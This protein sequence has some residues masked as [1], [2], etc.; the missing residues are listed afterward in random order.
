MQEIEINHPVVDF[1]KY[2]RDLF[3]NKEEYNHSLRLN[4]VSLN[5]IIYEL[6]EEG[7]YLKKIENFISYLI[8]NNC[9]VLIMNECGNKKIEL[10]NY[11][12]FFYKNKEQNIYEEYYLYFPFKGNENLIKEIK[13][14]TCKEL[15]L[16]EDELTLTLMT[17]QGEL[18]IDSFSFN[19]FFIT[20]QNIIQNV[21]TYISEFNEE[22]KTLKKD[23]FDD[24][25]VK[26]RLITFDKNVFNFEFTILNKAYHSL[27]LNEKNKRIIL[28]FFNKNIN[29]KFNRI[30]NKTI[31]FE[32]NNEINKLCFKNIIFN[33][34]YTNNEDLFENKTKEYLNEK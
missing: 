5:N 10:E 16:E 26:I 18:Y 25:D 9:K 33:I 6:E 3:I 11:L 27:M 15:N 8:E 12:E 29:T 4:Q 28:D 19:S 30:R 1:I 20:E 7:D 23:I 2:S 34:G 32:V 13:E 14:K 17:F 24:F 21:N 31:N 22:L